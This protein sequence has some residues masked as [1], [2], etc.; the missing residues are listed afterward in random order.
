MSRAIRRR[1]A[2]RTDLVEIF[3]YLA[4]EGG[5]RV[6]ERFLTHVEA[7]FARLAKM[8]GLGARYGHGHPALAELRYFPVSRFPKYIVF[9]QPIA[10][11]IRIFRVLH[12]AR[13]VAGIL[14]EEFGVEEDAVDDAGEPEA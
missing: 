8:P 1:R 7:T 5:L 10:E 14:A 12:G 11:G 9:Y 4:H 3:R 6:A 2:A 13:D